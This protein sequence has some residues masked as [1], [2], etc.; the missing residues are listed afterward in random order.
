MRSFAWLIVRINRANR[1]A[2]FRNPDLVLLSLIKRVA[3]TAASDF[4][5]PQG[6]DAQT[7]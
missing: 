1:H 7:N 6:K 5:K 3:G 2:S 4:H